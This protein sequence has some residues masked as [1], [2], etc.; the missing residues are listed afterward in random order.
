MLKPSLLP[1]PLLVKCLILPDALA[2]STAW[3]GSLSPQA[4]VTRVTCHASLLRGGGVH[5]LDER[6]VVAL[7]HDPSQ[8][9]PA[10]RLHVH[11]DG[12]VQHEVHVLVEAHD[13][14]VDAQV[15]LLVEPDLDAGAVLQVAED[16]VDGLNHHFL[17][18]L[19]A[20][21]VSHDDCWSS[22]LMEI[23]SLKYSKILNALSLM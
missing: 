15:H 17:H 12:V 4:G 16:E 19:S 3:L 5:G 2:E 21:L 18:L 20:S 10:V 8:L 7:E 22:R 23:I 9:L 1:L 13:A 14:A 6:D 11:L